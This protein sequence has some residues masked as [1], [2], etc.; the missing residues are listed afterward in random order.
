MRWCIER[1]RLKPG[2]TIL[3]PY[4]GSGPVGIAAVQ[5]GHSYIGIEIDPAY[6]AIAKKRIGEARKKVTDGTAA[7]RH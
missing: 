1:L 2:S 4:M 6:F 7:E 5:L 3:D